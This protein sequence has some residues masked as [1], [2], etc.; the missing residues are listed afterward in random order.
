MTCSIYGGDLSLFADHSEGTITLLVKR[1]YGQERI[2]LDIRDAKT[3]SAEILD[4]VRMLEP[5]C[6]EWPDDH[7]EP[8]EPDSIE[9]LGL[10]GLL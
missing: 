5:R 10:R 6:N 4:R 2:V 8:V 7:V 9:T 3:L 1:E